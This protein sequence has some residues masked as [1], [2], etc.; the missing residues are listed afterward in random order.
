MYLGLKLTHE[1]LKWNSQNSPIDKKW[2]GE[3]AFDEMA[4]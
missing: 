3:M 4:G 2:V 1:L